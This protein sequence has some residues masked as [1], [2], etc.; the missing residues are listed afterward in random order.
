MTVHGSWTVDRL[1]DEYTHHQRRTRGLRPHTVRYRAWFARK[2]VRAALGTDP[3]DPSRLT[4]A[5][6]VAFITSLRHR[7]S[8]ASM[9]TVRSSLRSFFRFL[10]VEG[11]CGDALET[12][13]P[14][15]AHWRLATLPRSLTEQ[16]VEQVLAS[17][18]PSTPCGQR[19]QAIVQCLATLGLRPGEVANLCLDDIDWRGG[20][21]QIRARKNRR[22]AVLPLP[23]VVGQALVAYLSRERPA[24]DERRVFVVHLW[25]WQPKKGPLWP[26]EKGPPVG[27]QYINAPSTQ[28]NCA[29]RCQPPGNPPSP[30]L[31]TPTPSRRFRS[32]AAFGVRWRGGSPGRSGWSGRARPGRAARPI[33]AIRAAGRA[34]CHPEGRSIAEDARS[35]LTRR[36]SRSYASPTSRQASRASRGAGPNRG[37]RPR[38]HQRPPGCRRRLRFVAA[39]RKL[40]PAV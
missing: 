13:L 28:R 11:F 22:G 38:R 37:A 6:V 31:P 15:V 3:I 17:V 12:A 5:A 10:R 33:T 36:P 9:R 18:D 25:K 19:D 24:T 32:G 39:N 16:Q 21:L 14:T 1:V 29:P 27:C 2:L 20:T 7:F 8:P 4:P 23:R 30:L 35:A 40:S 34:A 26:L